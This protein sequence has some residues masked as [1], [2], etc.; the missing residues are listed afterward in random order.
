MRMK[1]KTKMRMRSRRRWSL[2]PVAASILILACS[3]TLTAQKKKDTEPST[4]TLQG[5]VTDA[6][7]NPIEQAV[8]QL[9]DTRTLQVS[10]FITK[11]DGMYHF[12]GLRLD[13]EYQVRAERNELHADWKRI[14]VFD[15]RKVV[16][17]NFK[18]EK[19]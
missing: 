8:V 14:S 18:L 5:T 17:V 1:R 3:F 2:A 12:S 10:S 11:E 6:A 19:K 7:G 4:R 9:K 16:I 13:S 15:P